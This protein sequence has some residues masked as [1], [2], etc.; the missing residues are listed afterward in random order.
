MKSTERRKTIVIAEIGE[1]H[2]GDMA[3]ARKMVVEA[4]SA[5]ADIV[6]FQSYRG[7]DVAPDDPEKE[8][9][10]KV[11]LPDEMHFELKELSR[12]NGVE[13]LSS[14]FTV[15]RAIFLCEKVGLKKIKIAS[16][17]M[18]NFRLLDY[19]NQH[20]ETVF[21]STGLATIEEIRQAVKR[22][23]KVKDCCLLHCVTQYP[24]PPEEINLSVITRMR[25]EFPGYSIGFSDHTLGILAPVVAAA[26]GAEVIEKHFTL[27]KRLPGTDHV[28]SV[29]PPQLKEMVRQIRQV[30][31]LLGDPSRKPTEA[32][33]KIIQFVRNRFPK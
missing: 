29:D 27:D 31:T 19:V 18:L 15:E 2:I 20:A 16:S 10:T 1:N 6:K 33:K 21:L 25:Q 32:E 4:A 28:L 12:K 13:F 30:E 23:D 14:P 26:L 5:G 7:T 8:W 24:A 17:E 11:Q 9:F 22:L 3:L